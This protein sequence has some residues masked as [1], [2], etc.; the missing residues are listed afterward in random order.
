MLKRS[1]SA[2]IPPR[3]S[4]NPDRRS[5]HVNLTAREYALISERAAAANLSRP[6]FVREIALAFE[7]YRT[8]SPAELMTMATKA[9]ACVHDIASSPVFR[10][11]FNTWCRL[12]AELHTTNALLEG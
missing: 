3:S 4:L 8:T 6:R 1:D 7:I 5:L 2:L 10:L 9:I 12:E 11:S